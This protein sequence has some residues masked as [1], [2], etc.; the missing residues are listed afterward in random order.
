MVHE[1]LSG[2]GSQ[3]EEAPSLPDSW[4]QLSIL[5]GWG[6]VKEPGCLLAQQ[7]EPVDLGSHKEGI[8]YIA[9]ERDLEW[10]LEQA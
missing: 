1:I 9:E 2:E 3:C 5:Y 4:E 10:H 6:R 7:R 8:G